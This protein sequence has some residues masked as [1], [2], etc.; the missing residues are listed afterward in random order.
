MATGQPVS[1][2]GCFSTWPERGL[3]KGGWAL[4]CQNKVVNEI[5]TYFQCELQ[6]VRH[7]ETL[8]LSVEGAL[9]ACRALAP[10]AFAKI[11]TLPPSATTRA[12]I[13]G[14][15]PRRPTSRS[16]D[17]FFLFGITARPGTDM[18]IDHPPRLL[19]WGPQDHWDL[20]I[21]SGIFCLEQ[22]S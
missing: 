13:K 16:W 5:G 15:L 10:R 2:S 20:E 1:D 18:V 12:H 11:A 9:W 21:Y 6:F 22:N 8:P 19:F 4:N 17:P 14:S 7:P 3:W